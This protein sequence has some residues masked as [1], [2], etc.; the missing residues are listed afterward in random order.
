MN[1]LN[2]TFP[3]A[4]RLWESAVDSMELNDFFFVG[5]RCAAELALFECQ[6]ELADELDSLDI[7]ILL[8]LTRTVKNL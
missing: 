7:A 6:R 4:F 1:W 2:H 8:Q 5:F 3:E